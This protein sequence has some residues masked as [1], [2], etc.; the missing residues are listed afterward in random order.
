MDRCPPRVE[1]EE[2]ADVACW[3]DQFLH[4][5]VSRLL[6][7]VDERPAESWASPLEDVH[8]GG[9][10]LLLVFAEVVPPLAEL[11]V[12]STSQLIT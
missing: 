10:G 11:V 2:D 12:Y 5:G 4:V 6:D 1:C 8:R 3:W 9:D 7:G